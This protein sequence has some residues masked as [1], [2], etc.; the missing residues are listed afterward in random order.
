MR[1][2]GQPDSRTIL[3]SHGFDEEIGGPRG[4]KELAQVILKRYGP[5][6]IS[7]IVDEGFTGVD[8]EY[9]SSFARVGVAEKGC[10]SVTLSVLTEGGHSS[11]PPAHTG[12]GIMSRLLV[13][14]ENN[15]NLPRLRPGNPLLTYLECAAQYGEDMDPDLKAK[16]RLEECWPALADEFGRDRIMQTFLK[17]TQA[18]DI[19]NGG[20]KY[21]AL[22][23]VSGASPI[24]M[25]QLMGSPSRL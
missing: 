8:V 19:V 23:E 24:T 25:R 9:G 17:T 3:F 1:E 7:I 13:E 2:S 11:R 20:I 15:P 5:E 22:P 4:A 16:V 18:I 21:N 14:M 12:V 6:G 10:F